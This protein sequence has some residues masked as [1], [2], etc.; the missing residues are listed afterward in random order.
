M[1][2][3]FPFILSVLGIK[4][5]SQAQQHC[6]YLLPVESSLSCLYRFECLCCVCMCRDE[7]KENENRERKWYAHGTFVED[8]VRESVFAFCLQL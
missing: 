1:R 2:V 8:R 5:R 4:F 7:R 3:S 6:L